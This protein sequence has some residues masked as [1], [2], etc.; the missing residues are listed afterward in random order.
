MATVDFR[1]KSQLKVRANGRH[2]K[3]KNSSPFNQKF[4]FEEKLLV[5]ET[6]L[7]YM[8]LQI[9]YYNKFHTRPADQH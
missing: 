9:V 3:L 2:K 6:K 5:R 4:D 7:I 1:Q 8:Y